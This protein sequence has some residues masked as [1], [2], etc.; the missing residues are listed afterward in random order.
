LDGTAFLTRWLEIENRGDRPAALAQV[1]PWAG[2]VWWAGEPRTTRLQ[3]A[4]P[5]SLGRF[6]NT[7]ALFEGQFDW[8]DLPDGGC[9]LENVR[10]RSGHGCP[11]FVLRNNA[12]GEGAIGHLEYSGDWQMAF[13]NDHEPAMRPEPSARLYARIGL[14]GAAPLRV[15]ASGEAA[16]TPAVHLGQFYGDLDA[17][18]QELHRHLRRS[19][20]PAPPGDP[21]HPVECNHTGYTLN[22]QVTEAQ[23]LEEGYGRSPDRRT[24]AAPVVE[25]TRG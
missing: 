5:F 7:E 4:H 10:G 14:A 24:S 19:V 13:Y 1:F 16:R 20:V 22:A 3:T 25:G 12:T 17:G 15:L 18:V 9:H 11:F 8:E 21:V 2:M 23:L 6:R